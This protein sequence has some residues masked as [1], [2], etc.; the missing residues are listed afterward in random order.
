M[1]SY[2]ESLNNALVSVAEAV[3]P[4]I[5]SISVIS[6]VPRSQYGFRGFDPFED[7]FGFSPFGNRGQEDPDLKQRSGG[8][9]VI[10]STDR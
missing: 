5:V 9:G 8:S 10:I 2:A 4:T 1:D 3:N 7:F 6:E